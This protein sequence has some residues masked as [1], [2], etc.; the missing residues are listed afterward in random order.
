MLITNP[1][2]PDKPQVCLVPIDLLCLTVSLIST[3]T[4]LGNPNNPNH[5]NTNLSNQS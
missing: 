1:D 3:E 5:Y 4:L 2:N